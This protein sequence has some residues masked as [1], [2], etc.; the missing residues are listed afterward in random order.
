MESEFEPPWPE[1]SDQF[2]N[3]IKWHTPSS[4]IMRRIISAIMCLEKVGRHN[5]VDGRIYYPNTPGT[6]DWKPWHHIYAVSKIEKSRP[7]SPKI[8]PNGMYCIRLFYMGKWRRVTVDDYL[9]YDG[10]KNLLLPISS[11]NYDL[12]LPI[13][14]KALL[15]IAS[16]TWSREEDMVDFSVV[17]CLTGWIEYKLDCRS[18]SL[19]KVWKT[20]KL[21]LFEEPKENQKTNEFCLTCDTI[22]CLNHKNDHGCENYSSRI[23]FGVLDKTKQK[24]I[25]DVSPAAE[26]LV[27]FCNA[28]KYPVNYT[29]EVANWKNLRWVNW[30]IENNVIN[31]KPGSYLRII[32]LFSPFSRMITCPRSKEPEQVTQT[33]GRFFPD[34]IADQGNIFDLLLRAQIHVTVSQDDDQIIDDTLEFNFAEIYPYL[35]ELKIYYRYQDFY[36]SVSTNEIETF[37]DKISEKPDLIFGHRKSP[38]KSKF[39]QTADL[40]GSKPKFPDNEN[41]VE[42]SIDS[43]PQFETCR[44]FYLFSDTPFCKNIYFTISIV[45]ERPIKFGYLIFEKFSWKSVAFGP[46]LLG[47]RTIGTKTSLLQLGPGVQVCRV[48]YS[49]PSKYNLTINSGTF[50]SVLNAD[51]I[52]ELLSHYTKPLVIQGDKMLK[53]FKQLLPITPNTPEHVQLICRYKATLYPPGYK[54]FTIALQIKISKDYDEVFDDAF[55]RYIFDSSLPI[56]TKVAL[57]NDLKVIFNNQEFGEPFVQNLDKRMIKDIKKFRKELAFGITPSKII[58]KL[59]ILNELYK[60]NNMEPLDIPETIESKEGSKLEPIDLDQIL[61][62]NEETHIEVLR[63]ILNKKP[64]YLQFYPFMNEHY[65][66]LK[67]KNYEGITEVTPAHNWFIIARL[68]LN[69]HSTKAVPCG[70][71][72]IT[73]FPKAVLYVIDTD[74]CEKL[75]LPPGLSATFHLKRNKIGYTILLCGYATPDMIAEELSL[76]W[77]IRVLGIDSGNTLHQCDSINP[78]YCQERESFE[79]SLHI[80]N[81]T[82]YYLPNTKNIIGRFIITISKSMLATLYLSVSNEEVEICLTLNGANDE[83]IIKAEGKGSIFVPVVLLDLNYGVNSPENEEMHL[84]FGTIYLIGPWILTS[85]ELAFAKVIRS[86]SKKDIIS[87]GALYNELADETKAEVGNEMLEDKIEKDQEK[88]SIP[89]SIHTLGSEKPASEIP[90]SPNPIAASSSYSYCGYDSSHTES[91]DSTCKVESSSSSIGSDEDSIESS[92]DSST[93]FESVHNV[94][95]GKMIGVSNESSGILESTLHSSS[96]RSVTKKK[97]LRIV[98]DPFGL[99]GAGPHWVLSFIVDSH[100]D[101]SAFV[102]ND[103]IEYEDFQKLKE[104]WE[105]QNPKRLKKGQRLRKDFLSVYKNDFLKFQLDPENISISDFSEENFPSNEELHSNLDRNDSDYTIRTPNKHFTYPAHLSSNVLGSLCHDG[106]SKLYPDLENKSNY[107]FLKPDGLPKPDEKDSEN[108]KSLE[109]AT[110]VSQKKLLVESENPKRSQDLLIHKV[111]AKTKKKL[112]NIIFQ[113]DLSC[114]SFISKDSKN[115]KEIIT[116]CPPSP[117]MTN[118][119][120]KCYSLPF[121][122][123]PTFMKLIPNMHE[124]PPLNEEELRKICF[125]KKVSFPA[126]YRKLVAPVLWSITNNKIPY[127]LKDLPIQ[128]YSQKRFSDKLEKTLKIIQQERHKE[129]LDP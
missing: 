16:L 26:H 27:Y 40:A 24:E 28:Q 95:S 29:Q 47:V 97:Y 125:K 44:F 69:I 115:A 108:K 1:W 66:L 42:S 63:N 48:F 109:S 64:Q 81:I 43:S 102:N 61:F 91:K 35:R 57:L 7:S 4:G 80:Q 104:Y 11:T 87:L 98:E 86:S 12:W 55:T 126:V 45:R 111:L 68:T 50:Y 56:R 54:D 67:Y 110:K 2:I 21:Q 13:L 9:P 128:A 78:Y 112:E 90:S 92:S 123:R 116:K 3:D 71:Y 120:I 100:F 10:D 101:D 72:V 22:T 25:K 75:S 113:D 8:N 37:V 51:K 70:I 60:D 82:G 20:I 36:E 99:C 117:V 18:I 33:G 89:K 17:T 105:E 32:G 30:A 23:V 76:A 103:Y 41:E 106:A 119:L 62:L 124:T 15:R 46:L 5:P 94:S 49:L 114:S 79:A 96:E 73:E 127:C 74:N 59:K 52:H 77:K 88:A 107:C 83:T 6:S 58:P 14:S 53:G 118:A 129:G 34:S 19:D 38:R 31:A 85:T 122:G 65:L 93:S 39:K 84:F 121:E